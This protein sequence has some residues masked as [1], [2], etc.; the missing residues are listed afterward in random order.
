MNKAL[1]WDFDG[2]L[3]YSPH[4]W[5]ESAYKA[6]KNHIADTDIRFEDIR[7]LTRTG[8]PW[9]TYANDHTALIGEAW[10]DYIVERFTEI[11][12]ELGVEDKVADDIS[13][14]I[15]EIIL[16]IN[17]YNLYED[18]V[19]TL[20]EA[21]KAGYSNYI[22]SNNYPELFDIAKNLGIEKWFKDFIVS[23]KIGYD[24]PRK[25][26]YEYAIKTAGYPEICY[27]I[28]DNPIA[29]IKGAKEMGIPAILVHRESESEADYKFS[30]LKEILSV[31]E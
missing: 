31:L 7:P 12:K 1:F 9:H 24:K 4:L 15:R 28:G 14:S 13:R 11:Y 25:E 6:L 29:D 17:N 5:T 23:G 3:V 2:T 10:W 26:I 20:K 30:S 16:D 19:P 27:M 8:F 22:V 18:A 21:E